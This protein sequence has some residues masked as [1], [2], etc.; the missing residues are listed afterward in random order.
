MIRIG[1]PGTGFFMQ[2]MDLILPVH[3]PLFPFLTN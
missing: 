3:K 2:G 1:G